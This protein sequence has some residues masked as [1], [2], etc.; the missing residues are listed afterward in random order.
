MLIAWAERSAERFR[1][2]A[3]TD[4]ARG[5]IAVGLMK[6]FGELKE[7]EARAKRDPD[8]ALVYARDRRRR[9]VD[10]GPAALGG[11]PPGLHGRIRRALATHRGVQG[12][13]RG[14]GGNIARAASAAAQAGPRR[15]ADGA[16]GRDHALAEHG[17]L[18]QAQ[19]HERGLGRGP[20][21][22][23]LAACRLD[24]PRADQPSD[25]LARVAARRRQEGRR[26]AA[27]R[28]VEIDVRSCQAGRPDQGHERP[29]VR[30]RRL[31]GSHQHAQRAVA[32]AGG[33]S[34]GRPGRAGRRHPR[35]RDGRRG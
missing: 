7:F 16:R 17:H 14:S 32:R 28:R 18:P 26:A 19:G 34:P 31:Q 30:A 22:D 5:Y 3:T 25:Q 29:G 10:E 4:S 9:S 24:A 11:R 20:G 6:V 8:G 35:L 33:V 27:H 15:L 1:N 2:P 23:H 12:R 13:G 21:R